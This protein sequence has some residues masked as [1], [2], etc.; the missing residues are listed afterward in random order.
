MIYNP[1]L[2]NSSYICARKL[3][4]CVCTLI[5]V[6]TMHMCIH[7]HTHGVQNIAF[8]VVPRVP[9]SLYLLASS[10]PS[11]LASESQRSSSWATLALRLQACIRMGLAFLLG[12]WGSNSGLHAYTASASSVKPIVQ[13]CFLLTNVLT[14][15][16]LHIYKRKLFKT[17]CCDGCITIARYIYI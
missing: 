10:L 8:S 15:N 14:N 3:C 6:Y 4:V 13:A 7:M 11:R 9:S 16:F 12:C 2:C 5:P 17:D 1:Q